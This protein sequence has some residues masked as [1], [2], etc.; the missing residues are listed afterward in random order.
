LA[1]SFWFPQNKLRSDFEQDSSQSRFL[2]GRAPE[3]GRI[4]TSLKMLWHSPELLRYETQNL[5]ARHGF[6][7]AAGYEPLMMDRYSRVFGGS[8]GYNTP[9]FDAPLDPQI[10]NPRWQGIDL[11]NVRYV[12]QQA[13]QREWTEKDGV[14]FA[15]ADPKQFQFNVEAGSSAIFAGPSAEVDT[16]SLVTVT[17]NSTLL[18]Q[19]AKVADLIIHTADG[20]RIEREM[21]A[22]IDTAEWAY[23]RPDVKA[24]IRHSMP[25]LYARILWEGVTYLRYWTKFDLGGKTAVD[26][27]ELKC[28]AEGVTLVVFKATLYDSSGDGTFLL[29][30]QLPAQAMKAKGPPHAHW[31]KVYDQDSVQIYE[32]PRALPRAWMVPRVEVVSA[33]ESLRRVRGES[34]EPF[35]PREAALLELEGISRSD[36]PQGEFKEPAEARIVSYEANQLAIETVADKSAVLVASEVNYPGWEATIDGRPAEILTADYLLRGVIVP[37]GRHRVEMRY[38]APAARHGA[39]ITA[40]TLL[41]LGG[42]VIFGRHNTV[43]LQN[44]LISND[45]IIPQT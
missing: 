27:I 1:S 23:E 40:F 16:L 29:E 26:R 3:E 37:E 38:T 12:I 24:A 20:R 39:I 32:N 42:M 31:R 35:N 34:K 22:G 25:R 10:L 11:L 13:P 4:Y 41:A 28:V 15:S 21:K 33:E 17:A 30:P 36:L 44:Q 8:Y 14:R 5:P 18:P 19:G 6:H 2:A 9:T 43:R 7:N 45:E